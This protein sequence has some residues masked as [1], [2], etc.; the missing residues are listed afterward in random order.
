MTEPELLSSLGNL[1]DNDVNLP[2]LAKQ[3]SCG[4]GVV[5]FVGA[6]LS[7]PYHFPQWG[8]FIRDLAERAGVVTK[9]RAYLEALQY[10]EAAELLQKRL[11]S[12][13]F[14]D[15][16]AH[17]FGDDVLKDA[18]FQG[19]VALV[20]QI[21]IGP[22]ITTNF[23]RLLEN[24]F[25]ARGCR[26][27]VCVWHDK[28][29]AMLGSLAR[30]SL[31]LLKLHGDWQFPDQRVLALSEYR[32]Q[33]G[34]KTKI[35][36]H[37][38][39]PQAL[40]HLV[41]RPMLFLGCSLQQDRTARIIAE[42]AA[43][44]PAMRHYAI[45]EYPGSKARYQTR[46]RELEL[47]QIRPIWFQQKQYQ[48]IDLVLTFLAELLPE[49]QRRVKTPRTKRAE[50]IPRLS[51]AF[52]GRV[53]ERNAL[54]AKILQFPLVTVA[55]A[56]GAGKTRL[57]IEVACSLETDFD[58]IWFVTL[59]Q[60]SDVATLPQRIANVMQVKSGP[61]TDIVEAVIAALK[62]GRQ[63][64][65]LD[66][67]ETALAE[68]TA[69]VRKLLEDCPSLHLVLTSRIKL[70]DAVGMGTEHVYQVPPL[71]M[72]DPD[73]L[74]AVA[75]LARVDSMELFVERVQTHSDTFC[76]TEKNAKKAAELCQRLEGIP[77][78]VELV[79]AQM[80]GLSL[81][82]VLTNLKQYLDFQ[83][84]VTVDGHE[85]QVVTLRKTICLSYD[86]L[87]REPNGERLRSLFRRLSAFHHGWTIL[88]ALAVCGEPGDTERDI[89]D[90]LVAIRR[91]SLI[92]AEELAGEKRY[93][94]LDSIREFASGELALAH[95]D[96]A[97]RVRH[98]HWA[99]EFAERWSPELLGEQQ[100][101]ALAR[102][103]G[104]IDNLRGA[105]LWAHQQNVADIA[106][107]LASALW[108]MM[109]IRGRYRDGR[110]LLRKALDLPGAD[111]LP[112]LRS[113]AL[114]GLSRLAF[115]QGDLETSERCSRES[116]E[117]EHQYGADAGIAIALNDLGNVEASRG[118]HRKALD[119]F[120]EAL[121]IHRQTGNDRGLA[122]ALYNCG[123]SA[124]MLGLLDQAS[125]N[126]RESLEMFEKAG[127]QREAAFALDSL[128][129]LAHQQGQ[130][131]VALLYADRSL[132]IRELLE[133]RDGMAD[134]LRTKAAVLIGRAD[135]AGARELLKK[136]ADIVVEIDD[137]R[138]QIETLE[139]LAWLNS[140]DGALATTVELY[141][142]AEEQRKK[143]GMPIRTVDQVVRD[144]RLQHARERL[145]PPAYSAAWE[146]G[147]CLST[148]EAIAAELNRG[149][150]RTG[151]VKR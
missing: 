25:A 86:L 95:E 48:Q 17:S 122:V 64:L 119:R 70:G 80:E 145:G 79:A 43:R 34:S 73:K 16:I 135:C 15:L 134:T 2:E 83:G 1:P 151:K 26:F 44:N 110:E 124:L 47:M 137:E 107:R 19:A 89:R 144:A 65:V 78:A 24:V 91:T 23:D 140:V 75:E 118:E 63:L 40:E 112:A 101:V 5:P 72:P 33:Y 50:S 143:L 87:G 7:A 90:L 147:R 116:L 10:E 115:C 104:E 150:N 37:L 31:A 76:L 49:A 42:L 96:E 139:Y 46:I 29:Y 13:R 38:P 74:P 69:I 128:A 106:L 62:P 114:S 57:T 54:R 126:L 85:L 4:T 88:A 32:K 56:P 30:N 125:E 133:D 132:A 55:G 92:E 6:G 28:A 18:V 36:F 52:V 117:L 121:K 45:L 111:K 14:Q 127:N 20:P 148:K 146:K 108:P 109:E 129:E 66:N 11:G 35:D 103:N 131:E 105:T 3:M 68:C 123:Y 94:Y 21:T 22:V 41:A 149:T 113:K 71:K 39:I 9:V 136:S 81:D 61:S 141:S 100:A 98:A 27:P 58:D 130:D 84:V 93:R 12:S 60:L 8:E 51:S 120:A 102:M 67:C 77:L 138:G 53:E 142:T 82:S 97:L 99:T 59:S